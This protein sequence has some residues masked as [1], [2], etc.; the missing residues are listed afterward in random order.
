MPLGG[1]PAQNDFNTFYFWSENSS[2]KFAMPKRKCVF[3]LE[4]LRDQIFLN[5]E[6]EMFRLFHKTLSQSLHT[7]YEIISVNSVT[8]SL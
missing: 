8:N 7:G 1:P 4:V 5:L 6:Y 2:E 3:S